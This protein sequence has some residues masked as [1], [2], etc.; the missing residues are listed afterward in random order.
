M[1]LA[2]TTSPVGIGLE[3][4]VAVSTSVREGSL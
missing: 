1:G 2:E 3:C 4:G